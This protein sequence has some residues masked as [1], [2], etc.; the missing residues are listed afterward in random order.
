MDITIIKI[1]NFKMAVF[2]EFRFMKSATLILRE[3]DLDDF[4]IEQ[5]CQVVVFEPQNV[6]KLISRKF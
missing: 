1:V 5:K 3:I 4:K 2:E 6:S